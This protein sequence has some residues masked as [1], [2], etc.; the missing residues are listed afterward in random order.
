MKKLLFLH[1]LALISCVAVYAQGE[2]SFL[3]NNSLQAHKQNIWVAAVDGKGSF[4]DEILP[5]AEFLST[6]TYGVAD[7]VGIAFTES[8]LLANDYTIEMY[9]S[10]ESVGKSKLIDFANRTSANGIYLEDGQLVIDGKKSKPI[11]T[12]SQYVHL[13]FVYTKT[14][15]MMVYADQEKVLNYQDKSKQFEVSSSEII[16][17]F[18]SD[19]ESEIAGTA[20]NI[21]L[22]KIY[23]YQLDGQDVKDVYAYL[24]KTLRGILDNIIVRGDLLDASTLGPIEGAK[25]VVTSETV[26]AQTQTNPN[27]KFS[28]VGSPGSVYN[29]RIH[30]KG[31]VDYEETITVT[32]PNKFLEVK[33]V[34]LSAGQTIRLESV[35]FETGKHEVLPEAY[36]ELNKLAELMVENSKMKIELGGHTDNSGG[37]NLSIELS[38]KR[39]QAVKEYLMNKGVSKSRIVGKGYGF[40]KP[41]ANNSTEEGRKQ[42][43]RVEFTILKF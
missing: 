41:I 43:R 26:H 33:L 5:N 37:Q 17:F 35:H 4:E 10:A 24:P 21:A 30:K 31:Y 14:N 12:G 40:S 22:L 13:L 1:F 9:I 34:P 25:V 6:Y 16:Q 7:S 20:A 36:G 39:V 32:R 2:V 18:V 23:P 11:F 8:E 3:F 38:E 27:G 19:C 28:L 29:V 15:E 42:N